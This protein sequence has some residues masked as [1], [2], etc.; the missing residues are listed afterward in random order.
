M[1]IRRSVELKVH[2]S[3]MS[4][5]GERADMSPSNKSDSVI[6]P[7][8]SL[9]SRVIVLLFCLENNPMIVQDIEISW[10]YNWLLGE[11]QNVRFKVQLFFLQSYSFLLNLSRV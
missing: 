4:I 10:V 7:L 5:P 2:N 8:I 9:V 3:P 1:A 11:G 6:A